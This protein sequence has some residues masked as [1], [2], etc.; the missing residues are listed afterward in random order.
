VINA[1]SMAIRG[2]PYDAHRNIE[3]TWGQPGFVVETDTC[4][5]IHSDGRLIGYAEVEDT[6]SPHVQVHSWIRVHPDVRG[7]GLEAALLSWIERRAQ[8]AVAKAPEH[9][10]VTLAQGVLDQDETIHAVFQIRG[11]SIVRY[12]TKMVIDLDREI[13]SPVWPDEVTIRTFVLESDLEDLVHAYRDSFQDHWGH[14]ER[15]FEE[16]LKA[17]DYWI[18]DDS[19]FD[20]ALTFL[21]VSGDQVV[22]FASCDPRDPEDPKM[23]HIAV[24][25]VRRGWRRQGIALALLRHAFREFQSRGQKRVCLGVDATSLTGANLLYE[26]AGMRPDRKIDLYQK[27]LRDGVDISRQTLEVEELQD[28]IP[29]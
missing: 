21:A 2:V 5:A 28:E 23:G 22:G 16:D 20:P 4:V 1:Y 6:E 27:V 10:Q 11:Y 13:P 9:A 29:S 8:Q 12:F 19:E 24:L 18:R 25:G 14:V 7:E 3:L 17:W 15:T 26:A